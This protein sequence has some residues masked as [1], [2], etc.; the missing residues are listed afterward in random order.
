MR[1]TEPGATPSLD[2]LAADLSLISSLSPSALSTVYGAVAGLEAALRTRLFVLTADRH[3]EKEAD[4]VLTI[5]EA[6]ALL[7]TSK[8]ALYRKWPSLKSA[9]KDPLDGRLKFRRRGLERYLA[10]R[11]VRGNTS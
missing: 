5:G 2:A 4:E 1:A 6:A 7:R 11:Q 9:F 10:D 3:T 8:D